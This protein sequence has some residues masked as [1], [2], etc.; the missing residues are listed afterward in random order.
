MV[1]VQIQ[2]INFDLVTFF[3]LSI[4]LSLDL[5]PNEVFESFILDL[6]TGLNKAL[7]F[8]GKGF[9]WLKVFPVFSF[10]FCSF[11]IPSKIK[12]D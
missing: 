9:N 2:L 11:F 1:K 10:A 7:D 8:T 12:Y 3:E 5:F 4:L 6:L